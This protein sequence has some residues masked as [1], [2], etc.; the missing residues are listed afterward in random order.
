MG[1]VAAC[2]PA[3]ASPTPQEEAK[4]LGPHAGQAQALLPPTL[5]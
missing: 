3:E 2:S 5:P 1:A 4:L